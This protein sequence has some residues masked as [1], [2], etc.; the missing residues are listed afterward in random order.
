MNTNPIYV[1]AK[2]QVKPGRI[3]TVKALLAEVALKSREEKGNLFYNAYQGNAD[4]NTVMLAEAYADQTALDEH[5][6]SAHFQKIVVEQI[7]PE[8]ENREVI[9]SSQLNF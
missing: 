2:W 1:F 6:N 5:R 4:E 3:D 9:L 8:L 7:V